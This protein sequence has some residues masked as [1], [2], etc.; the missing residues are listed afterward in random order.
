MT[1]RPRTPVA[2]LAGEAF[3]VLVI[4]GGIVGAG[5]AR[6]AAA[7]GLRVLLVERADFASGT[8]GRSSRLLH[9]GLRYLAQMRFGLVREAS[10]E[11]MTLSR[12]AP[13]L[14]EPLPFLFPV[15]RGSGWWLG[16]LTLGVWL[17]DLL[18]GGTNL[19]RSA[20]LDADQVRRLVPQLRPDGLA[21]ATRH[22]DAL[23][24][25]ARLVLDTL[26]SAAEDGA[27]LRNYAEFVAAEPNGDGWRCTLRDEQTGA[28]VEVTARAVVN[29]AG[30]FAA[31]FP[32]SGVRLRLTKGVHVVLDRRR[33]PVDEAIVLAKGRRILFVIPWGERL[34][35]GTTDTDYAGDPAAV[36]TEPAD[37]RYL[38][39]VVNGAFPGVR[40]GP[41]DV[42]AT[43]AG[44]R[45]L[46]A[47][48]QR[49]GSPSDISRAHVIAMPHP[50]WFDVAGGKLTT[51]RLMAEQ[52]VDRIGRHFNLRLGPSRTA[53]RPLVRG[54][55]SAVLPPPVGP[56][57]V[58]EACR[59]EW[60]VH[61]DDVLLRRTS[62]HYYH[63]DHDAI[64]G[65][66]AAW[67]ADH[68]GWDAGRRAAELARHRSVVDPAG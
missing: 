30:A 65:R 1:D 55:F 53:E 33:L 2:A 57:P 4:G 16:Q 42:I 59:R 12:I 45:P 32:R 13:H 20:S 50:G 29:A 31:G 15:R 34:I 26:L 36:R 58:A 21:G 25:D 6:D 7:R 43:W 48:G 60:A 27:T 22:Y 28:A 41:A 62:W 38:L 63:A 61:L 11:K 10:V 19:G 68:L 9:G 64:A 23:T 8:S 37:V 40:L 52:T 17:Y 46:V 3:D 18:C 35:V 47:A 24:N 51:Y 56:E 49:V 14:C 54:R 67:M 5:V 39:D 66:V 44:V